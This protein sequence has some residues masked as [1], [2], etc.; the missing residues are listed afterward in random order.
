MPGL[1]RIV[2]TAGALH[3]EAHQLAKGVVAHT[4]AQI[5][6]GVAEAAISSAGR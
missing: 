3:L 2:I 6:L 4:A 1:G 5:V